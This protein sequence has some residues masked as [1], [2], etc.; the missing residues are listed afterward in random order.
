MS[1]EK[2][3][4]IA[5]IGAGIVGLATAYQLSKQRGL[6]VLILEAEKEIADHQT[7]NNSGVIHSGLYY[8]PGS[9]K[10]Q[11]CVSGR[12]AMYVFCENNEIA[13]ERCGKLVVA[14]TPSEKK[15]LALLEKRGRENGL[16]GLKLL[17]AEQMR[18]YEPHVRGVAA[19]HVPE[20]GIVDYKDVARAM[21]WHIRNR[22]HELRLES[23]FLALSRETDGTLVLETTAGTFRAKNLINCGGL[24]SDRI[25]RA[26]G[27]NPG[28]RIIP[29]RGEYYDIIPERQSL[30]NNLIYPVPNPRFPFLGVHFTRMIHGGVEAG[31]NAVLAF[32]REGYYK[33]DFDF[34][35][36]MDVFGYPGFW[37][38]ALKYGLYGMAEFYRSF[39][40]RA[41]VGAL[42]KLVPEITARDVRPAG[43]GVRAQ[44]LG[45]GGKLIDDFYFVDAPGQ[46]HVLNAPSPAA[47]ASLS[48]GAAIAGKAREQFEF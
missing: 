25:A 11:N 33:K 1:S 8:T 34:R 27:L 12:D 3:Y 5:I 10:A 21:A 19:L 7:G 37:V 16:H 46:I 38:L 47:T 28:V 18:E 30:V 13:H 43:A 26:C 31:P 44:A 40:R 41:F 42:Q 35:D 24:Y 23:R 9:L 14:T 22:G 36:T 4:D 2:T 17:G 39:S 45:A 6:S 32:K 15:M 20:T 48:I 29:F